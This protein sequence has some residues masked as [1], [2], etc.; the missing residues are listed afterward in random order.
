[1]NLILKALRGEIQNEIAKDGATCESLLPNR[2]E[3]V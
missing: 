1:V 2:N 3:I